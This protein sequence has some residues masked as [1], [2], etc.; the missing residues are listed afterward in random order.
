MAV[1]FVDY[2][3]VSLSGG[4]RGAEYLNSRDRLLVFYS[5]ICGKIRNIDYEKIKKAKC[6][7]KI[8]KLINPGKNALDFYIATRVGME[9]QK[10][11]RQLV[12]VSKDKGFSAVRDFINAIP[13]TVNRKIVQ[14]SSIEQGL[15]MLSDVGNEHRRSVIAENNGL[16]DIAEAQ[17]Y[18]QAK[19]DLRDAIEEALMGTRF[20]KESSKIIDFVDSDIKPS[21]KMIYSNTLHEYGIKDGL[22]L[23][24]ILKEVV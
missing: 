5:E 17:A 15:L 21:K 10:G 9:Y 23:Y 4:L 16:R 24:R 7:F 20:E 22:E 3:N 18:I 1:I 13:C 19:A 11:E 2:E 8:H 12:I 14:S 6:D